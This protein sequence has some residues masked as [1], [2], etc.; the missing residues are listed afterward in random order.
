[1][2]PHA[3]SQTV[4]IRLRAGDVVAVGRRDERW[5]DWVWCTTPDGRAG[6]VPEAFLC[7]EPARCISGAPAVDLSGT[8]S[9]QRL[10]TAL[11]DYDASE[12][13]V[14]TGETVDVLEEVSGW[15]LCRHG[16]DVGWVPAECI[17]S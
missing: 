13:T 10:A 1:M 2:R 11:R 17:D 14:Q 4:S 6:W 12:L 16:A 8:G 15:L 9:P 3:T 5:T 7:T